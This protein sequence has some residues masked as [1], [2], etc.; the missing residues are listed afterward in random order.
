MGNLTTVTFKWDEEEYEDFK[1][2][3]IQ[4]QANGDLDSDVTRSEVIRAILEDW[5]E[6]PSPQVF[7][8]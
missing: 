5:K 8:E 3:I 6:D 1:Q 2:A 4:L 7:A